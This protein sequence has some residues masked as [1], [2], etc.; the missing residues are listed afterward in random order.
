M[1]GNGCVNYRVTEAGE[2]GANPNPNHTEIPSQSSMD[3]CFKKTDIF[4][5][6]AQCLRL[7]AVLLEDWDLIPSTHMVPFKLLYLQIQGV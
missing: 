7:L 3:A 1:S 5:K 6:M 4:V 2:N